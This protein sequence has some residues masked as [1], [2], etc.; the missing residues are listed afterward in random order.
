M[1]RIGTRLEHGASYARRYSSHLALLLPLQVPPGD[2]ADYLAARD[3][4]A[5]LYGSLLR[6]L[7][8]MGVTHYGMD[9][10]PTK[11]AQYTLVQLN[12]SLMQTPPNGM[13]QH[14]VHD[15]T[16]LSDKGRLTHMRAAP[17]LSPLSSLYR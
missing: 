15:G 4:V 9:Q 7:L 16:R 6:R 14:M 12:Q 3:A 11:V 1:V 13:Q 17:Q 10:D 8:G 2:D 5:G